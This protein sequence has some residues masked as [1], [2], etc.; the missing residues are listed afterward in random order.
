MEHVGKY[1]SPM[2]PMGDKNAWKFRINIYQ[3]CSEEWVKQSCFN[4]FPNTQR[5]NTLATREYKNDISKQTSFEF[6][7]TYRLRMGILAWI[8]GPK[9]LDSDWAVFA[10]LEITLWL[11]AFRYCTIQCN[12]GLRCF[13]ITHSRKPPTLCHLMIFKIQVLQVRAAHSLTSLTVKYPLT[14][15]ACK[16]IFSF[17]LILGPFGY[18]QGQVS[19]YHVSIYIRTSTLP[20]IIMVRW[21]M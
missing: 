6:I 2:D 5:F 3:T 13:K 11:E 8:S 18:F 9:S 15:T 19:T 17:S 16:T 7:R 20:P 4:T 12:L 14:D 21:K 10:E 1:T